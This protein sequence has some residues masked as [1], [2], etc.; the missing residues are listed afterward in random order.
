MLKKLLAVLAVPI[1]A[2]SC[3]SIQTAKHP[4]ALTIHTAEAAL[5]LADETEELLRC[6]KPTAI[7][8]HCIDD[9][10]NKRLAEKFVLGFKY[11]Q[12]ARD[13]YVAVPDGNPTPPQIAAL[14]LKVATIV[15]EVL[16]DLPSSK[17]K[18]ELLKAKQVQAVVAQGVN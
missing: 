18:D 7:P 15:Q 9:A 16:A 3:A 8:D 12:E 5:A 2:L 4:A 10:T 14:A 6:G 11:V 1:L 13:L 17:P